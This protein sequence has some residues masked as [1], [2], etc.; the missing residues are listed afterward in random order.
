MDKLLNFLGLCRRAGKLTT[1]SDAVVEKIVNGEALLVIFAGDI[2]A[3]TEKKISKSCAL[4]SVKLLKINRT[5]EDLSVAVGRF[6]AVAAVT[7]KGFAKNLE[8]LILNE[9]GGNSV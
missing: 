3:N 1:G 9:S 7:E 8:R 4:N 2:S 6:T 5:K